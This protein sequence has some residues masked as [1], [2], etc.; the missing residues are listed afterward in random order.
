LLRCQ[1][2]VQ[3]F[4]R[5]LDLP[6]SRAFEIAPEKRFQHEDKGKALFAFHFLAKNIGTDLYGLMQGYRHAVNL[7]L[8]GREVPSSEFRDPGRRKRLFVSI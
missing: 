1:A 2:F 7:K 3:N 4:L 5:I 8:V 6:A